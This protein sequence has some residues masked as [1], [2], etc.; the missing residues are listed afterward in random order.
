M[1]TQP[2]DTSVMSLES[3]LMTYHAYAHSIMSY[4]IVFWGK[5]IH[6][7]KIFKIKKRV[8][9]IIMK[10]S[11]RDSY[12]PL[13]KALNILF[14]SQYIFPISNFVAKSSPLKN[15]C[16]WALFIL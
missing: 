7:D 3:L 4:D 10:V 5:S 2:T 1:A 11:I 16:R 9:R 13:F 15:F 12:R 14:Y 6:S 8:I